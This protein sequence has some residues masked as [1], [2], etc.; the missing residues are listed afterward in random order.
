MR[1]EFEMAE[2]VWKNHPPKDSNPF[3]DD[4]NDED[5]TL[6]DDLD[7]DTLVAQSGSFRYRELSLE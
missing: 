5:D 2:G 4:D 1:W 7:D 6:A 3:R